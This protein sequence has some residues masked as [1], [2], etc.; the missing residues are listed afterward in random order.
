MNQ[1]PPSLH[2]IDGFVFD[3]DGTLYLGEDALPG[4]VDTLAAI[5]RQGKKVLF[6]SNKP[7]YPRETYADKLTRLGIPA[8][9]EEVITSAYVLGYHLSRT[10]RELRYYVIGEANLKA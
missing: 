10:A 5:R 9:P 4:A 8:Q 6:L 1:T 7:L 2:S 3:L